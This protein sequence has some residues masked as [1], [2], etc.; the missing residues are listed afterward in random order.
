[1]IGDIVVLT[2]IK[3]KYNTV[4]KNPRCLIHKFCAGKM[5]GLLPDK[6]A[7]RL[8]Y[9]GVFG[10]KLDLK[11]P[12][13]FNAKLQWLKLYDRNEIYTTMVDKIAAKHYIAQILGEKYVIPLYGTWDHFDEIDFDRL[14]GQFVLKCNHDSGNVVICSDKATFNRGKA[15]SIL[16]SALR[17]NTFVKSREWPYKNI[18]P[19]ILAEKLLRPDADSSDVP[20]YKLMVF[21][22]KVRCLFVCTNR[23]TGNGLNVTFFDRDWSILPFE[24]HYPKDPLPIPRP[25]KLD[26]MIE[27]AERIAQNLIF[28]R[29]DLYCAENR[30]F[31]GEI[32]LY[33]GGG[34]EEFEPAE[35]DRILGDWIEL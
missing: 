15:R 11:A 9:F 17:K 34:F 4:V 2:E 27:V 25:G 6:A 5:F 7:L 3:R 12:K 31:F 26:E 22:G 35:Y 13:T 23:F 19:R 33:P 20:D 32:T 21:G 28:C 1:M 29:V 24:R 8:L 10:E 14:P 30:L 18:K 16:E